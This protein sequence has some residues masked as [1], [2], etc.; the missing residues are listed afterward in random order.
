MRC[1]FSP[2]NM[3]VHFAI[4]AL[5]FPPSRQDGFG[6]ERCSRRVVPGQSISI[7]PVA[8]ACDPCGGKRCF[9]LLAAFRPGHRPLRAC[10][11]SKAS[12]KR[13][14]IPA[15]HRLEMIELLMT[16]VTLQHSNNATRFL[17]AENGDQEC[18]RSRFHLHLSLAG[19]SFDPPDFLLAFEACLFGAVR[20]E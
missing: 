5:W 7:N 6:W 10:S 4:G 18:G 2:R 13:P 1:I 12:P 16:P 9:W 15:R 11:R 14:K 17:Q 8:C 3:A 20:F 19:A